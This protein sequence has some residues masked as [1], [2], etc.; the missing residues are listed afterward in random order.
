MT[1]L[2]PTVFSNAARPFVIAKV[3][4]AAASNAVKQKVS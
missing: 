4:D 1:P 3:L 2:F